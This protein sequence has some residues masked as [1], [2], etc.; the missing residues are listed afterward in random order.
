MSVLKYLMRFKPF[1]EACNDD[2]L[3]SIFDNISLLH[4]KYHQVYTY[5]Y[6][7]IYMCVFYSIA[8]SL[9]IVSPIPPGNQSHGRLGNPM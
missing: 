8:I 3:S 9:S 5:I 2:M 6:T 7:Y 4:I 1:V